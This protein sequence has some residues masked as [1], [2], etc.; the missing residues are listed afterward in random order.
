MFTQASVEFSA[1]FTNVFNSQSWNRILY[2]TNVPPPPPP[3]HTHTHTRHPLHPLPTPP[4]KGGWTYCFWDRSRQHRHE[5]F[6][7]LCKLNTLRNILM[8]LDRNVEQRDDLSHT[9]MTTLSFLLFELLPFVSFEIDFV[10][11]L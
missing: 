1:H 11:A 10:F 3:T 5:T 4:P 9:R 8:I 6:C 7:P 2:M